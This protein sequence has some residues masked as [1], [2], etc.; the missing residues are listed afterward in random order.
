VPADK[1]EALR[2]FRLAVGQGEPKAAQE[3]ERLGE[4]AGDQ[5]EEGC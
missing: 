1:Q 5:T 4:S 3:L 2:L